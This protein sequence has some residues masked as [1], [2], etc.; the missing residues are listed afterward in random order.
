MTTGLSGPALLPLGLDAVVVRF[1]TALDDA[2]NRAAIAFRSTVEA[3]G[4]PGVVETA[5]SLASVL[6]R[7]DRSQ[8]TRAET[9]AALKTLLGTRDWTEAELPVG[10]RLWRVPAAFGGAHGPQLSEAAALAGL[11]EGAA[12]ASI[13]AQP[14]R[15]LAIGFAPGQPYLG[16]LPDRWDI[17]RMRNLTPTV[18]AGAIVVAVRQIV[19]FA[20]A[21]PT[22]W[23]QIGRT[24][25]RCFRP[26]TDDPFPLR[27]GDE[28]RFFPAG[29]S[30]LDA[31][32][33]CEALS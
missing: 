21:S 28:V 24:G 17:P 6:V 1:A 16:L 5:P 29:D 11:S 27:A 19:L 14:L 7:F 9:T 25:F 15:V 12:I 26:D 8:T 23:R 20:N 2:A 32:A 3:A 30:A 10:R 31:E 13:T 18:P 4:L 33:T 22:G